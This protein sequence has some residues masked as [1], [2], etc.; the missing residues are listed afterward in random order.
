MN[1]Q[2][3]APVETSAQL[4]DLAFRKARERANTK[5]IKG[6]REDLIAKRES[7]KLDVSKDILVERLQKILQQFP[8]EREL[9]SFYQDMLQLTLDYPLYK[10]SLG[11]IKWTIE[12]VSQI[13]REYVRRI[14]QQDLPQR[15]KLLSREY[16]G[17]I[18]SVLKQIN[19]NLLYLEKARYILRTYPDIKE[20]FTVCLYGFPNVGKTTILNQL[21]GSKAKVAAYAFTTTGINSG[22]LKGK[23][24]EIQLLDVPG[25]LARPEKMN[26]IEL[27][28][29]LVR[30]K[31]ADIIIFVFDATETCGYTIDEQLKLLQK[32]GT[33]KPLL[34]YYSKQDLANPALLPAQHKNLAEIKEE[35]IQKAQSIIH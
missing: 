15:Q 13:H 1:F 34:L 24:Y 5:K 10:K 14:N 20:M 31:V 28:A 7:I 27:I 9:P 4:L 8:K 17:R 21:S 3:L 23:D 29:E 2:Y 26:N 6:P 12:K 32:V 22:F 18:S 25:T 19:P 30:E 16:F 11:A 35:L 33:T